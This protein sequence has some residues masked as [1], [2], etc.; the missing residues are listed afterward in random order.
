M[1]ASQRSPSPRARP[2]TRLQA[3][4]GLLDRAVDVVAVVALGRA[5]EDVDLV[6][7]LARA[8]RVLQ[9][10]HVGDQHRHAH[11]LGRVDP[12]EHL[13]GVGELRDHVGAD[14]ARGL[15]A[16]Q[17]GA[18]ERVRA[19]GSCRRS[20]RPRARSGSRRAGRPRGCA[21]RWAAGSRGHPSDGQRV[22]MVPGLP[23]PVAIIG[24]S[25]ALGFGLAIRWGRAG[26]PVVLG[27]RDAGR[28]EE[29]AARARELVPGGDVHA[30]ANA[31][32]AAA[33]EVVVLCVPFRN[34]SETLTNLKET[35]RE[36][37]IVVDATV[38]LAAAVSGK[39]T[40][41]LGVWQGSAAQQAQEMVPDGV[42]VVSA[43]HTVSA[44]PAARPRA[45]ARRGRPGLR[46]P[47]GRQGAR[48][49]ADR[50]LI[51]G[52]RSVD[53]GRLEMARI[54]EG[55]TP[56]LISINIRNKTHA[57]I[58]ITGLPSSDRRPGRRNRR[59]Q[60]RPRPA[61]RGRRRPRRD[62]EHRRRRRDL[63]RARLPRPRPVRVLAGRPHRRARLGPAR[64]HLPRDGPAA[65]AGRRRLVQPRRPR[66][67]DRPAPRRAPGA[68]RVAHRGARP[69]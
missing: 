46:R 18:H 48:H 3:G 28:A 25:G 49:G 34:Q 56:L 44:E 69:S 2:S 26:V 29:A 50:T 59:R 37:Q 57:G 67:G 1:T 5:E 12:G 53:C 42:R 30:A 35:L 55:L 39:A 8:Q 9:P 16:P 20:G 36:G 51:D 54:I 22:A 63:P 14:E 23:E 58:R 60:A 68:G 27:S 41:L 15:D 45:R 65:R 13:V 40:R 21:P 38:P 31:E 10:A 62:R 52:L 43:L 66:P 32:A 61:R 6:E 19:G 33:A 64:R 7:A 11:A 4:Q 24:A 47:Q 17:A